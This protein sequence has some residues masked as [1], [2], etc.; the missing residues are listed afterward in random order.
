M[1]EPRQIRF[2]VPP[3]FFFA[4]LLWGAHLDPQV[5]LANLL[6]PDSLGALLGTVAAITIFVIPLAILSIPPIQRTE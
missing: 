4:A 5:E 6:D 1:D 2:L 3:F